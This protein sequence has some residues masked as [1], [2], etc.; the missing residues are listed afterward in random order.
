MPTHDVMQSGNDMDQ[1][2]RRCCCCHTMVLLSPSFWGQPKG[3]KKG[4]R[5]RDGVSEESE[6]EN[7]KNKEREEI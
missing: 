2:E 4:K 5:R 6:N 7:K 3:E 1:S